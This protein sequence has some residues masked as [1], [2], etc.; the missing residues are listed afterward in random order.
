MLRDGSRRVEA[1]AAAGLDTT[2]IDPTSIDG[3]G[4]TD[5]MLMD[6][7]GAV[8]NSIRQMWAFTSSSVNDGRFVVK[9]GS[10]PALPSSSR[11]HVS[12]CMVTSVVT[13]ATWP[14]NEKHSAPTVSRYEV[15]S[16]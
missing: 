5:V 10:R 8:T 3:I 7:A 2:S 4:S 15:W 6:E 12:A 14:H 9:P 16:G 1:P 13:R 11:R